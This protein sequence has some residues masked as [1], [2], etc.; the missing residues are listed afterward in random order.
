M[1]AD[2]QSSEDCVHPRGAI[3]TDERHVLYQLL[4][5][6]NESRMALLHKEV[7]PSCCYKRGFSK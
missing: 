3:H 2:Q 7:L 4:R 5:T 6:D 1:S